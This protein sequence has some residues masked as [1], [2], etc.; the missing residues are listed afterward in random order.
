LRTANGW[1]VPALGLAALLIGLGLQQTAESILA[2]YANSDVDANQPERL[3]ASAASK[4]GYHLLIES[5]R[6]FADAHARIKAGI[7]ALRLALEANSSELPDRSILQAGIDDL[8]AGLSRAPADS[9]AWMELAQARLAL[10]NGRGAMAALRTSLLFGPYDPNLSLWRCALGLQLWLLFD[11]RDRQMWDD[12]VKLAWDTNPA[13]V[14]AL[15]RSGEFMDR[16]IR[17]ALAN[18]PQRLD[19]FERTKN[20]S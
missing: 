8:E 2:L 18:S 13:G 9:A 4:T 10:N 1:K 5:D 3:T 11:E 7:I 12:Q 16:M 20:R 19:A 17:D 15:S 14:I 6:W